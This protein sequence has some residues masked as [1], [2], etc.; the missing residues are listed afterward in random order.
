MPLNESFESQL[1]KAI[2]VFRDVSISIQECSSLETTFRSQVEA[3]SHSMWVLTGLLSLIRDEGYVPRDRALFDQF[4]SSLSIGLSHQANMAAAGMSFTCL[5]RRELY[6]NHLQP[7]FSESLKHSLLASPVSFSQYLFP[8][9][10][11]DR[12]ISLTS[13]SSSLKSNQAM[14]DLAASA[15][16]RSR[17]PRRPLPR[18]PL[19]RSRRRNSR[20]PPRSPKRVRFAG[21]PPPSSSK[22]SPKSSFPK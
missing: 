15:V 18:S 20:S 6:V 2:P 19:S 21:T 16:G 4:V 17:S 22:S 7:I 14:V 13:Q 3:L 1:S 11:V 12:L 5:K 10:D 8:E 9:S